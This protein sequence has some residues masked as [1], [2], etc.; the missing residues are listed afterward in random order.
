MEH[1]DEAFA[2][3]SRFGRGCAQK[4]VEMFSNTDTLC[5]PRDVRCAMRLMFDRVAELGIAPRLTDI[6]VIDA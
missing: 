5:M 6:E 3:A 1:F 4:H 2:F